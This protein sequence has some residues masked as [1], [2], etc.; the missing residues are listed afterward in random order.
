M[1]KIVEVELNFPG[2]LKEEPIFY[3]IIKNFDVV[4]NIRE[5]SFSTEM[6]W[7]IVKFEGEEAELKRLFDYLLSWGVTIN[8][9]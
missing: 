7:G 1:K 8:I 5:A 2:K 9:L 3:Y 4:V 6:G